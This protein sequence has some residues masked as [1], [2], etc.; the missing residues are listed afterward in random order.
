[1]KE[2]K[3]TIKTLVAIKIFKWGYYVTIIISLT[4]PK[5]ANYLNHAPLHRHRGDSTV[6]RFHCSPAFSSNSRH[7]NYH[8]N[9]M[10]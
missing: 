1:M 9:L 10:K 6:C 2:N 5:G 3:V 7:T 4:S 8:V